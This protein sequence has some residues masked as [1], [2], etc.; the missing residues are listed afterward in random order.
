MTDLQALQAQLKERMIGTVTAYTTH[1]S[2][3]YADRLAKL[4]VASK[5]FKPLKAGWVPPLELGGL[6]HAHV[7]SWIKY[8]AKR[9]PGTSD[10]THDAL[11]TGVADLPLPHQPKRRL[12]LVGGGNSKDAGMALSEYLDALGLTADEAHPIAITSDILKAYF[13]DPTLFETPVAVQGTEL[14]E[15]MYEGNTQIHSLRHSDIRYDSKF[16]SLLTQ[17]WNMLRIIPSAAMAPGAP[18]P[19][20]VEMRTDGSTLRSWR[21][22]GEPWAIAG[23]AEVAAKLLEL[24]TASVAP[25]KLK[26]AAKPPVVQA[27]LPGA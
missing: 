8:V 13:Q 19:P 6:N 25:D 5:N 11:E 2:K 23:L 10:L 15:A 3:G 24:E 17:P 12:I 7:T 14:V 16:Q 1:D 26:K 21:R 27:R 22:W 4:E 9:V 20:P 18:I